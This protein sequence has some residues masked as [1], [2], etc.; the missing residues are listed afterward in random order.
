MANSDLKAALGFDPWLLPARTAGP[1]GWNDAA[2]PFS[3]LVGDTP[4]TLGVADHAVPDLPLV[5]INAGLVLW[6][7]E[8]GKDLTKA[9]EGNKGT[10]Y[11][12]KGASGIT[13]GYGYDM[14]ERT[15]T[16]VTNHLKAC[17]VAVDLAGVLGSGATKSATSE[18]KAEAFLKSEVVFHKTKKLYQELAIDQSAR[19]QLFDIVYKFYDQEVARICTKN[20]VAKKYGTTHWQ[21]LH[22]AIKAVLIDLRFRG[23]YHT[24]SR[25]YIQKSVALNSPKDFAAALKLFLNDHEDVYDDGIVTRFEKRITFVEQYGTVPVN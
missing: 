21:S 17:G 13:I 5:L 18:P 12:P 15:T 23:D 25:Q 8:R 22:P 1:M 6:I 9:C 16:E 11:W 7:L 3:D 20:D 10:P 4:G 2:V 14:K 19:D 24:E